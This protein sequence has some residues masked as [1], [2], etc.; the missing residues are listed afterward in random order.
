MPL[1]SDAVLLRVSVTT[2]QWDESGDC[3]T[4]T[5]FAPHELSLLLTQSYD[6][7]L[8]NR[9]KLTRRWRY[10]LSVTHGLQSGYKIYLGVVFAWTI[11]GGV[12]Y[13]YYQF[14][15]LFLEVPLIHNNHYSKN[16]FFFI[17]Y[18]FSYSSGP[19]CTHVS[20]KCLKYVFCQNLL[21]ILKH[22]RIARVS[23]I[24]PLTASCPQEIYD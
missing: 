7:V 15:Y 5:I 13:Q 3:I 17:C 4:K 16:I 23:P 1:L 8:T 12:E 9:L 20:K 14:F 24:S 22:F 21:H 11:L 6:T 10:L 19:I 2:V 18:V